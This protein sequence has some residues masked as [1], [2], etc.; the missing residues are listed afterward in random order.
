MCYYPDEYERKEIEELNKKRGWLVWYRGSWGSDAPEK[1]I[2]DGAEYA[3]EKD[4]VVVSV[5]CEDG[6]LHWG[7]TDQIEFIKEVK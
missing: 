3:D 6:D 4:A 7:Y 2:F 5:I 1:A